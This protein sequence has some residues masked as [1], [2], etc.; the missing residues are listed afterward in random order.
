MLRSV[1]TDN[2]PSA[3]N[4]AFSAP[5]LPCRLPHFQ[6]THLLSIKRLFQKPRPENYAVYEYEYLPA[7]ISNI[8]PE[9]H[10]NGNGQACGTGYREH[11]PA[12]AGLAQVGGD[13]L[14]WIHVGQGSKAAWV[15]ARGG[16]YNL[17]YKKTTFSLASRINGRIFIFTQRSP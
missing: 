7:W 8:S 14:G 6:Q 13:R 16:Y 3:L 2:Y 12:A 10:R 17:R 4:A 1:F 9:C 11:H 15:R 5:L